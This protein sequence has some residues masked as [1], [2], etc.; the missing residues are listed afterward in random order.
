MAAQATP[1]VGPF[2]QSCAMPL[3]SPEDFGT[4]QGGIRQNDYCRFCYDDG[5]FTDPRAT[6]EQMI[7]MSVGPWAQ[8]EGRPEADVRIDAQRFFPLLRRWRAHAG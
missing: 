7:E 8:A 3:R 6:M 2:C 5:T 1:Q 4:M